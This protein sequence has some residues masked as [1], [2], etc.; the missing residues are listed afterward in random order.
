MLVAGILLLLYFWVFLADVES[1][2]TSL[3]VSNAAAITAGLSL[4]VATISYFW[5]PRAKLV[6]SA[7]ASY[8]LLMLTSVLLISST[9]YLFSPFIALWMLVALF[10]PIFGWYGIVFTLLVMAS[11]LG[12]LG[13]GDGLTIDQLTTSLFITITPLI[14]GV[15]AWQASRDQVEEEDR[16]VSE[17]AREL[18][19]VAGKSEV[20]IAAIADGVVALDKNGTVSLINPAAQRIIGWGKND[21][22]GLDYKSILKLHDSHDKPIEPANDPIQKSLETN[23]E[24]SVDTFSIETAESGKKFLAH[25]TV[26]PIGP[27]GSGAIVVFRDITNERS[28]ERE[29]A[30]FISTASH[31]MRTP[32]ASIEGYLGLALNP[33]TAT[34]DDKARDYIG[35][36]QQAAQHL[37]RLFQDLLDVSRADDNRLSSNP[38]V[39]DL[40]PFVHDIVVGLTPKAEEKGLKVHYKPTPSSTDDESRHDK[41][42][43]TLQPVF[44]VNVDSDHLREVV[45]NLIENAIKYTLEGTVTIDITG[46]D[47]HAILSVA[48]SGIGIPQEDLSHLFQ[49]FY[50]VDNTATREIG[51]TGLGLYLSRKLTESME[52]RIW[53][54]SE[55]QRGSTFH[56]QLPRLDHV[57]AKRLIEQN[58]RAAKQAPPTISH[59]KVAP[60]AVNTP[61]ATAP[62][63]APKPM[64]PSPSIPAP[65]PAPSAPM[66]Q[67]APAPASTQPPTQ[68][69]APP[70]QPAAAVQAQPIQAPTMQPVVTVPAPQPV[71]PQA[72]PAAPAPATDTTAAQQAVRAAPVFTPGQA[73]VN[74]PISS[75]EQD[76]RQYIQDQARN[77]QDMPRQF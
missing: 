77:S 7:F 28:Q 30:E 76:P 70:L 24:I 12:W 20:V 72:P 10:G 41:G 5:A 23:K 8:A 61:P 46:D 47:S 35:K 39:I 50:R 40:V 44:Y 22:I 74:T 63:A 34:I 1:V 25:I 42:E 6:W 18:R 4:A 59:V 32:V 45:S 71:P 19:S 11:F 9:G 52:G 66:Q 13:Y 67:P 37:G 16:T 68:A 60:Q 43:K 36:A 57:E 33:T 65:T 51:G 62:V 54:E 27:L 17:L 75:I 29:Q 73:R 58:E 49:K 53:A 55:Y 48:D 31:E 56:M 3:I 21:A 14:V 2:S 64:P 26:S 69:P 38:Q 15:L